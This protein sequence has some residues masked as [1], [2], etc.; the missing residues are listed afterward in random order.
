MLMVLRCQQY[1]TT[2][3]PAFCVAMPFSRLLL[4]R[5]PRAVLC[6]SALQDLQ[7]LMQMAADMVTLAERF[8][9]SAAAQVSLHCVTY[10]LAD[11]SL[12]HPV[13]LSMLLKL[14]FLADD[15][16]LVCS[17]PVRAL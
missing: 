17:L 9:Q 11:S 12:H 7:N 3:A 2:Y 10:Q 14:T 8:R 1:T 15:S 5:I 6:V 13:R 16:C 4:A